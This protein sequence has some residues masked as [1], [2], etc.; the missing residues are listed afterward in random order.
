MNIVALSVMKVFLFFNG[1][2]IKTQNAPNV[3]QRILRRNFHL[4]V[5][6]VLMIQAQAVQEVHLSLGLV[7]VVEDLRSAKP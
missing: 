5:A 6:H 2:Q 3:V 7:A 1:V 4:L